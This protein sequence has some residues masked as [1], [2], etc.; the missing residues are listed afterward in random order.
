MLEFILKVVTIFFF[1]YFVWLFTGGAERGALREEA[2]TSSIFVGI[3]GTAL[4]SI[5]GAS[6]TI[7]GTE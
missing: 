4:N 6:S 1:V 5:G 3:E 7:E 2:G